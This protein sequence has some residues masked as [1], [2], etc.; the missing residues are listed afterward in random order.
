MQSF[1]FGNLRFISV[2]LEEHF[3]CRIYE[4]I[5][6]LRNMYHGIQDDERKLR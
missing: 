4:R 1:R 6:S 2:D 5:A 3:P